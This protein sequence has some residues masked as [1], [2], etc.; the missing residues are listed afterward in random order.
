MRYVFEMIVTAIAAAIFLGLLFVASTGH[1]A[2][3]TV[4]ETP[5]GRCFSYAMGE[6]GIRDA[7]TVCVSDVPD[8]TGDGTP[9]VEI[10][11]LEFRRYGRLSCASTILL[12]PTCP[13]TG[14]CRRYLYVD[15]TCF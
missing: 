5:N 10:R 13:T 1:A 14:T 2:S 6:A 3:P 15:R 9:E 11:A 7:L 4:Y 8:A 12:D